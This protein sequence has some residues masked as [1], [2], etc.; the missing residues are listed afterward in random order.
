SKEQ[1]DGARSQKEPRAPSPVRRRSRLGSSVHRPTLPLLA[2][3]GVLSFPIE[4]QLW[5][6]ESSFRIAHLNPCVV[7]P[8]KYLPGVASFIA[9]TVPDSVAVEVHVAAL[10]RLERD[11]VR[12]TLPV[13]VDFNMN[14]V[15]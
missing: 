8:N 2:V 5:Y 11:L 7:P 12:S 10:V 1:G 15:V 6:C 4:R 9:P 3:P 14:C 13:L